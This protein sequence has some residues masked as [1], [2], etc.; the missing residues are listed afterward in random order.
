MNR[1]AN[2]IFRRTDPRW[3]ALD[4]HTTGRGLRWHARLV[5]GRSARESRASAN[6]PRAHGLVFLEEEV[7]GLDDHERPGRLS[8]SLG[9]GIAPVAAERPDGHVRPEE[10]VT[11][12]F[13]GSCA[14]DRLVAEVAA[15]RPPTAGADGYSDLIVWSRRRSVLMNLAAAGSSQPRASA[16]RRTT[17]GVAAGATRCVATDSLYGIEQAR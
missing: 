16:T 17:S 3:G 8:P 5:R 9:L 6:A 4:P 14:A 13:E 1:P 11:A 12:I 7:V 10:V 15:A 2:A